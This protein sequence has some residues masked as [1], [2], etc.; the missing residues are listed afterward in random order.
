MCASEEVDSVIDI[1]N[2]SKNMLR[3]Y[4]FIVTL[5]CCCYFVGNSKQSL[6]H[7]LHE[8]FSSDS[9]AFTSELLENLED[10]FSLY[11]MHG[12]MFCIFNSSTTHWCFICYEIVNTSSTNDS[13]HIVLKVIL[14][15]KPK[16]LE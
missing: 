8:T 9:E 10:M 6:V 15:E 2:A 13:M 5:H 3:F 1:S 16:I 14:M 7:D 4:S 11:D 12:N